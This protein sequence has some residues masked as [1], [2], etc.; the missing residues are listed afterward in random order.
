MSKKALK[1]SVIARSGFKYDDGLIV[2]YAS[3]PMVDLGDERYRDQIPADLWLK[4][5]T[6]FFYEGA[7][8]NFMHRN[9]IAGKTVKI[10]LDENGP[11]LYTRP[12]KQYVKMMVDEGDLNG[13]SIEY[14]VYDWDLKDNP[15]PFD[16]RPIR[17][18]KD[19]DV[20]RISYVD[21]PMNPGSTFIGGKSLNFEDFHYTFDMEKGAVT[22]VANTPDSF[23]QLT[24]LFAD[25]LGFSDDELP[26]VKEISIKMAGSEAA[27]EEK[28]HRAANPFKKAIDALTA[29]GANTQ[30][31]TVKDTGLKAQVADLTG[32]VTEAM[33]KFTELELTA[34][35]VAELKEQIDALSALV[36]EEPAEGEKSVTERIA[37]LEANVTASELATEVT[38]LKET[39]ESI[40][41]LLESERGKS[42]FVK[43]VPSKEV[44]PWGA[45]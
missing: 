16:D 29:F 43:P 2:G 37:D 11:L 10:E 24:G 4:A 1:G 9:I 25:G 45:Y 17:V 21:Q 35:Q 42:T 32:K 27:H 34:E 38:E 15:D 6:G 39:V 41:S 14:S 7:T 40:V 12:L 26:S 19:F 31:D 3:T 33:E 44:D 23:A 22:V 30:E 18:F 8:I 36:P 28:E 20:W 5:L 13:Y